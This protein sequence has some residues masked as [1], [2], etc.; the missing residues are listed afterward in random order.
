M[1]TTFTPA[2]NA[3]KSPKIKYTTCSRQ[4]ILVATSK[5]HNYGKKLLILFTIET[6]SLI[7][8]PNK[9]RHDKKLHGFIKNSPI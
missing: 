8:S 4:L 1:N 6:R 2:S 5:D 3:R 9:T 7:S